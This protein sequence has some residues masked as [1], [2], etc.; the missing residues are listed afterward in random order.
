[1]LSGL[2][3]SPLQI[4]EVRAGR[5]GSRSPQPGEHQAG[6]GPW[7]ASLEKLPVLPPYAASFQSDSACMARFAFIR[8]A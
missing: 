1:M 2:S 8:T 4:V 6:D 7:K 3:L 5:L